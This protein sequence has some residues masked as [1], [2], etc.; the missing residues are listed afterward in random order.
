MNNQNKKPIHNPDKTS[1]IMAAL[2]RF[3]LRRTFPPDQPYIPQPDQN[4]VNPSFDFDGG[5]TEIEADVQSLHGKSI[6]F[7]TQKS[8]QVDDFGHAKGLTQ[9]T[10]YII[11]NGKRV[12]N[13]E[14]IGGVC[15]FCQALAAQAVQE[16]KLTI[17]QVQLQSLF[18]IKSARQCSI[19]G[20]YT[21]SIHC[22]PL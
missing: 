14:D 1:G 21:C 22:R 19:C 3:V 20:I 9:K 11:G 8:I 15:R 12:S 4:V 13:I 16:G 2:K 7:G 18:D 6:T 17:E 10:S 5:L